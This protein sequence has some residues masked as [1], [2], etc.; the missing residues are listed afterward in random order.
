MNI[1]PVLFICGFFVIILGIYQFIPIIYALLNGENA[2]P[3]ILSSAMSIFLGLLLSI[4]TYEKIE[5]I[6]LKQTFLLTTITWF[7]ASI[8]SAIPLY[9]YPNLNLSFTDSIFETASGLTT[10]GATILSGLDNMPKTILLWRVALNWL[11]GIGIIVLCI[12]VL[13]F[14]KVGGMQL[15]Q[16][17]S[18]DKSGRFLQKPNK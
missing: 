2:N 15:F 13:P 18:S 7:L 9:L 10:T 16:T 6:N 12:G 14:L 1:R 3:F 8:L 4:S 11:G 5:R 17:E